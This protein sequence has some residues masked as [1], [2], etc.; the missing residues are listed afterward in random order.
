[1]QAMASHQRQRGNAGLQIPDLTLCVCTVVTLIQARATAKVTQVSNFLR[2]VADPTCT[3]TQTHA[4]LP[5]A[6]MGGDR[7][8]G[9][10]PAPPPAGDA[11]GSGVTPPGQSAMERTG[12][13]G[14]FSFS[15][16]YSLIRKGW[17]GVLEEADAHYLMPGTDSAEALGSELER[18]RAAINVGPAG[19]ARPAAAPPPRCPAQQHARM[20]LTFAAGSSCSR[21]PPLAAPGW[22]TTCPG[23]PNFFFLLAAGTPQAAPAPQGAAEHHHQGAH[24]AVLVAAADAELLGADGDGSQ[25]GRGTAQLPSTWAAVVAGPPISTSA[26]AAARQLPGMGL[27]LFMPIPQAMDTPPSAA[28]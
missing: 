11:G 12:L 17:G 8:S 18:L 15:W 28:N 25:V 26:P 6:G 21:Q 19:S 5:A 24:A 20:T 13:W 3:P 27:C 2:T 7:P 10:G 14:Y 1:M 9:S 4:L 23:A 16:T 22:H